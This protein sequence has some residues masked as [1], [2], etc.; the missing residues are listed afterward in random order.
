METCETKRV[1]ESKTTTRSP[2]PAHTLRPLLCSTSALPSSSLCCSCTSTVG[3]SSVGLYSSSSLTNLPIAC[4]S[5]SYPL[6][7]A[8][9]L[10]PN[11]NIP[12]YVFLQSPQ[13]WDPSAASRPVTQSSQDQIVS[14]NGHFIL[15]FQVTLAWGLCKDHE[16]SLIRY[17]DTGHCL[18]VTPHF[19]L[20]KQGCH[21]A[22]TIFFTCS[23]SH[24]CNSTFLPQALRDRRSLPKHSETLHLLT[25]VE[26]TVIPP[27]L[28]PDSTYQNPISNASP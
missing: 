26:L 18:A 20:R 19:C 1:Q 5:A 7:C 9:Q 3:E 27:L 21:I 12:P 25:V 17:I 15:R 10:Q 11:L 16:Q 24:P 2:C 22:L 4:S 23:P 14:R 13:H 8:F 6:L 28:R